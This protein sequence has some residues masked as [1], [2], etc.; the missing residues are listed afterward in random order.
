MVVVSDAYCH[1]YDILLSDLFNCAMSEQLRMFSGY[2]A[3]KDQIF[4]F[5]ECRIR[6]VPIRLF[7]DAGVSFNVKTTR[8]LVYSC[9]SSAIREW[10]LSQQPLWE[11]IKI[12]EFSIVVQ[13]GSVRM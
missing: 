3:K 9:A 1:N 5:E 11:L 4:L 6:P 7:R 2:L 13:T 8:A 12:D 10:R